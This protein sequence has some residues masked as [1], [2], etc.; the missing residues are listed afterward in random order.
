M[1]DWFHLNEVSNLPLINPSRTIPQQQ[2]IKNQIGPIN[3]TGWNSIPKVLFIEKEALKRLIIT[4]NELH[5]SIQKPE[6]TAI[7]VDIFFFS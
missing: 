6:S 5:S 4:K 7:H 1:E 3:K 2:R